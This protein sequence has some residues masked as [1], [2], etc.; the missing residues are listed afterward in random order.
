MHATKFRKFQKK[1]LTFSLRA[2]KVRHNLM[3]QTS[4][5]RVAR[6]AV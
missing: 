3:K 5:R 4:K 1:C 6:L 2:S